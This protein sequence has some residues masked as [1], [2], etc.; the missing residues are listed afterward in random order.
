MPNTFALIQKYVDRLDAVYAKASCTADLEADPETVR[1]GSKANEVLIPKMDMD[2]LGDYS[3]TDGYAAG[4]ASLE[5]QTKTFDYDR[6]RK[7]SVDAMDNEETASLAFGKLAGEFVRTKVA[8]ELDAYRFAK[9][10]SLAGT[11]KSED[12]ADATALC[13]AVNRALTELDEAEIPAEGRLLY[14]C[15]AL[16]N[17]VNEL[18]TYKSKAMFAEFSKII[19]VPQKRFYSA[20]DLLSGRTDDE[21]TGGYRTSE[22]GK[23]INFMIIHPQTVIQITKHRVNKTIAPEANQSADAWL[24]FF[25]SYGL[26]E[27]YDN[28]KMGIYSSISAT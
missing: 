3:R 20:V 12:I 27:V 5:W 15:P 17:G 11:T 10:T 26:A 23:K 22:G 9:Y 8:P 18:D 7:F 6:G 28:K 1:M 4:A 14:I 13:A 19:R 16:H 24:H 2:G 25:R 21:F